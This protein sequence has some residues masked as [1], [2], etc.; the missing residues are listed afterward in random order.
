MRAVDWDRLA[1]Q[2]A[3]DLLSALL[4][5]VI[6]AQRVDGS[7]GDDGAD[8]VRRDGTD[9]HV[10]EVKKFS[11][12][13]TASQKAQIQ[14]SLARAVERRTGMTHWHLVL[15]LDH[16]PAEEAWF[17]G[18]RAAHPGLELFWYGR[19][20]IEV[21][22]AAN[23]WI[24]RAFLPSGPE[25]LALKYLA[26]A[27]QESA[28]L[29]R[30]LAD[31]LPRFASLSS[32]LDETD[33]D[34]R[35]E[36]TSSATSQS[37]AVVPRDPHALAR[38]PV[39]GHISVQAE[40]GSAGAEAL[41][42]FLSYGTPLEEG[43]VE[44]I[45]V[46][47]EG[48]P[49]G[50]ETLL[51]AGHATSAEIR[52]GPFN[53]VAGQLALKQGGVVTARRQ[54]VLADASRGILGGSR[55]VI[56]DSAGGLSIELQME[57][58]GGA[59]KAVMQVSLADLPVHVALDLVGFVKALKEAEALEF[60]FQ[61]A[62][63]AIQVK[64]HPADVAAHLGNVEEV[65]TAMQRIQDRCGA[66][67]TARA[68]LTAQEV[69]DIF[70]VDQLLRAGE[71]DVPLVAGALT[72]DAKAIREAID[73]QLFPRLHLHGIASDGLEV[74]RQK[75]TPPGDV[76]LHITNLVVT[77]APALRSLLHA[78]DAPAQVEVLIEPDNFSS[79]KVTL[80]RKPT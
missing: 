5:R 25:Q 67:L 23:P 49:E 54:C 12:R 60:H 35:F 79:A 11:K 26:G 17:E 63:D 2:D 53:P 78:I 69:A 64:G 27:S 16:S 8:L 55:A 19:T 52:P 32:L 6:G 39:T 43:A 76:E 48:L 21:D 1:P 58:S 46:K 51:E 22:V 73:R 68:T 80:R 10:Y 65:L 28:G 30:G 13:L 31:A 36:V 41:E 34:F 33:P 44:V 74:A 70:N 66:A 47:L 37:V 18:V 20:S 7:G 71:I 15:P 62:T 56:T 72:C 38:R 4:V 42:S 59:G 14:K 75:L 29:A 3:E 57:P 77:N 50:I 61:G 9:L 45:D 40:A 24:A